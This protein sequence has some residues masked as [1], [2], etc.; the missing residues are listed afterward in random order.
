M[1]EQKYDYR[2][3]ILLVVVGGRKIESQSTEKSLLDLEG[4]PN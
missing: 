4:Q 2:R 1:V 3:D